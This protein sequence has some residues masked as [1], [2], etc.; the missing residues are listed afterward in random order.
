MYLSF[1]KRC[2]FSII[3]ISTGREKSKINLKLTVDFCVGQRYSIRH[4]QKNTYSKASSQ[5]VS[6]PFLYGTKDK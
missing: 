6:P 3:E 4:I 5:N 1:P 2:S